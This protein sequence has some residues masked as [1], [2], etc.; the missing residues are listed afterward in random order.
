MLCSGLGSQGQQERHGHS[1]WIPVKGH[2]NFKGMGTNLIQGV[3]ER[4]ES[5]RPEEDTEQ[6]L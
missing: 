1:G 6:D 5:V 3:A 4:A 2:E